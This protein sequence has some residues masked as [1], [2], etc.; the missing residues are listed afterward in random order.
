MSKNILIPK[1]L[2][3]N[4]WV[5]KHFV[6]KKFGSRNCWSKKIFIP[7]KDKYCQGKC[8]L[9][10][11]YCDLWVGKRFNRLVELELELSLAIY[12]RQFYKY[13]AENFTNI[14]KISPQISTK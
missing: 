11:C 7:D 3:K 4:I 9:D 6:F 2:D 13:Q 10:K 12:T 14:Y 5:L 8:C 1:I